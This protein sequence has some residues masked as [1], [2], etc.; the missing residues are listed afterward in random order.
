[1]L[2]ANEELRFLNASLAYLAPILIKLRPSFLIANMILA[3]YESVP[4]KKADWAKK[5][6]ESWWEQRQVLEQNLWKPG[7]EVRASGNKGMTCG[8]IL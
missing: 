1:M 4:Q 5:R 6:S 8:K 3:R 2:Q 7:I